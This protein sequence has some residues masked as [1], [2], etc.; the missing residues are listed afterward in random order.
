[1]ANYDVEFIEMCIH[2]YSMLHL[3]V[4]RMY[5]IC[6]SE[7]KRSKDSNRGKTEQWVQIRIEKTNQ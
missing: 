6:K 4:R 1:M 2:G 3:V 7:D 5:V